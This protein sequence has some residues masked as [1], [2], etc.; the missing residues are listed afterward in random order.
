MQDVILFKMKSILIRFLYT[1][2]YSDNIIRSNCRNQL[3]KAHITSYTS[4][5]F[6]YYDL[7]IR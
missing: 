3:H 6:F 7:N 5:V 1:K 4:I 2:G